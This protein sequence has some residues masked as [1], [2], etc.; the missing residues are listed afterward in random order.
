MTRRYRAVA[1][2]YDGTLAYA[3]RPTDEVLEALAALRASG[4]RVI[5]VTGR[6]HWHLEADFAEV[7]ACFDALVL[8]NGAVVQRAG[9]ELERLAPPVPRELARLLEARGLPVH[10]GEVL[11]ALPAVH[12]P[13]VVQAMAELGLDAGWQRV[14]NRAS[15]MILPA[16]VDKGTGVRAALDGFAIAPEET[17]GLGDAENDAELIEA[18]G[19]G[20]AVADAVDGLKARA[21]LVLDVPGAAGMAAFLRSVL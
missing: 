19:L 13:L 9:R 4:V 17:I 18:C 10:E 6:V 2:D 16:G 12:E 7:D 1:S 21:R 20:V 15:L 14:R 8:E 5:L 3:R 11:L